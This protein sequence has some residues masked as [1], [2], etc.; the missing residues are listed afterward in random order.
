[1]RQT[2]DPTPAAESPGAGAVLLLMAAVFLLWSAM[3]ALVQTV[4]HADNVEQL[5]WSHFLEWGYL[6]HPPLS[7]WLTHAALT[8]LPPTDLTTYALAMACVAATLWITWRAAR[9]VLDAEGAWIAVLLTSADYY[10]MGRGSFLNHNTVMLPFVAAS[11]WAVLSIVR[12][13]GW[14]AWLVLGLA[15]A[16]GMLTKYQMAVVILANGLALLAAGC[17]RRP[18]FLRDASLACAAT[19]LPLFPHALWLPQNGFSSF[20]YA[21]HSLLA[22]LGVLE[23]VREA[24]VFLVQQVGRLAPALVV[25]AV[26]VGISWRAPSPPAPLPDGE[27]GKTDRPSPPGRGEGVRVSRALLLLTWIPVTCVLV[28][29]L[30]LGVSPQNHWGATTT[31]LVPLFA[32]TRLRTRLRARPVL[33]GVACVHAVAAIFLLVYASLIKPE[34][35]NRFPAAGLAEEALLAWKA[36]VAGPLRV[37]IGPDWEAGALAMHLPGFPYALSSG[38]RAQAP[39]VTDPLLERCGALLVWRPAQDEAAQVGEIFAARARDAGEIHAVGPRGEQS[40]LRIAVIAPVQAGVCV[41]GQ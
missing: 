18:D 17:Y 20:E 29:T 11:A 24:L 8:V 28:L 32:V 3:P 27:G 35:H 15:Q 2:D 39:W 12:G 41:E 37:V 1:M 6:K 16:A 13:A 10:L 33:L 19:L 38:K 30:F 34:F 9:L 4:P 23:R 31:I 25:G 14:S 21:G 5:G 40:S 22:D 26:V 36:R 7:T